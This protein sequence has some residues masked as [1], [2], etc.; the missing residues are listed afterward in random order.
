MKKIT[1][2]VM[3]MALLAAVLTSTITGCNQGGK[4]TETLPTTSR[5]PPS[6]AL[7]SAAALGMAQAAGPFQVTLTTDP[8]APTEG[9]ARLSAVVTRSS[10]PVDDAEVSAA[11]SM[12]TMK[13]GGPNITL[14]HKGGGRYEG[15]VSLSMGGVWQAVVTVTDDGGT[16]TATYSF[17]AMQK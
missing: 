15:P 8:A 16:G 9:A 1:I 2:T 17:T 14:E 5:T 13:M 6:A 11:L 4:Q 3:G 12:P 7:S 10:I